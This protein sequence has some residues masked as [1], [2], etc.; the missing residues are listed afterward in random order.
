MD[1]EYDKLIDSSIADMC[2]IG[3]RNAG[4][5]TAAC[6]LQRFIENKTKWAHIDIAGMDLSKG[7]NDMYPKGASGYGVIL[8]NELLK[9]L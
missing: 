8:L 4:S 1:E 9:K 3:G 2:N 5:A 6:F 7:N